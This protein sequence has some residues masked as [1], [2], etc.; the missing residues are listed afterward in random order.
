MNALR[1][2]THLIGKILGRCKYYELNYIYI[3][4][5]YIR[6]FC[7]AGEEKARKRSP[8]QVVQ[9]GQGQQGIPPPP[10]SYYGQPVPAPPQAYS[11]MQHIP[12]MTE[13]K[14]GPRMITLSSTSGV[15]GVQAYRP[16]T[17]NVV[18]E[19]GYHTASSESAGQGHHIPVTSPLVIKTEAGMLQ[20]RQMATLPPK[21]SPSRMAA[22]VQEEQTKVKESTE[23]KQTESRPISPGLLAYVQQQQLELQRRQQQQIQQQ[24][25]VQEMKR[26]SPHPEH[27]YVKDPSTERRTPPASRQAALVHHG[28][29]AA[30]RAVVHV[31]PV[32][33]IPPVHVPVMLRPD[34]TT[35]QE[36]GLL[37]QQ[38]QKGVPV[39]GSGQAEG[40]PDPQNIF[41]AYK[42]AS[43]AE[44]REAGHMTAVS[45]GLSQSR[46]AM[47]QGEMPER[48][49][50]GDIRHVGSFLDPQPA[51]IGDRLSP[52]PPQQVSV[53]R[54]RQVK[55]PGPS[56]GTHWWQAVPWPPTTGQC[57]SVKVRLIYY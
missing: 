50:G 30:A 4:Y 29:E 55:L 56:A 39:S 11:G 12:G 1:P 31:P 7:D 46:I 42:Q 10:L 35:S 44:Q 53:C 6:D 52:G 23:T 27:A 34:I 33:V 38:L 40:L 8:A 47:S 3:L 15:T 2:P 45:Q 21:K 16:S 9:K 24:Q 37:R 32:H 14:V 19:Q 5:K 28:N 26:Y 54:S 48:M 43:K 49:L 18:G 17:S 22:L 41:S 13:R 36:Y 51:H 20:G 57:M 25:M